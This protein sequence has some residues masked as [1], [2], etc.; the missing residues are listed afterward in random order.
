MAKRR[1]F[2]PENPMNAS[3]EGRVV[4]SALGSIGDWF[5]SQYS[6]VKQDLGISHRPSKNA[7]AGI[8]SMWK[9]SAA[10]SK[11]TRTTPAHHPARV[12]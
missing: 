10:L 11:P 3:L 4:L 8:L 5:A 7:A 1:S 2:I 9:D 6:N 12:K